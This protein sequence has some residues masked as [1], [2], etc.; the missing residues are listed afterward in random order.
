MN[1]HLR[2]LKLSLTYAFFIVV[3]LWLIRLVES[4][5]GFE[6]YTFGILPRETQG[7]IGILTSPLVHANWEH[8]IANTVP[9]FILT[10]ILFFFYRMKSLYILPLLWL[11][12]GLMTWTIGR[13]SWHIGASSVIY[14]LASF[15]VFGGLFSKNIKLIIVAV[16]IAVAYYGLIFGIF[17]GAEEV[18]WEGYLS[19]FLSGLLW[20]YVFR[21][22]LQNTK[23]LNI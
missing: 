7:L 21:K 16:V 5:F 20:A 15:L 17:P 6:F 4:L 19:G 18:S 8:L 2:Y 1:E 11:T 14:A 10:S 9:I 23:E 3:V 12:A 22:H 13:V